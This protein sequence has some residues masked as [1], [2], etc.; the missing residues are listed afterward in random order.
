MLVI[1]LVSTTPRQA[2]AIARHEAIAI[3]RRLDIPVSI[4]GHTP[5]SS[6]DR[7]PSTCPLC[8]PRGDFAPGA[9]LYAS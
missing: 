6:D 1:P 5:I 4:E 2:P 9:L 7:C 8:F 3:A